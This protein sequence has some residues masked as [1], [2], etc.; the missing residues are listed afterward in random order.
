MLPQQ[1]EGAADNTPAAFGD[2]HAA[3]GLTAA[4]AG[5]GDHEPLFDQD[6]LAA[7]A[8]AVPGWAAVAAAAGSGELLDEDGSWLEAAADSAGGADGLLAAGGSG[9]FRAASGY[10]NFSLSRSGQ[11]AVSGLGVPLPRAGSNKWVR[12][13]L[14]TQE[15]ELFPGGEEPPGLFDYEAGLAQA[16]TQPEPAVQLQYMPEEFKPRSRREA[17]Y[18]IKWT[19]WVGQQERRAR[20]FNYEEKA[21]YYMCTQNKESHNHVVLEVLWASAATAGCL[22]GGGNRWDSLYPVWAR[23]EHRWYPT[24]RFAAYNKYVGENIGE[25]TVKPAPGADQEEDFDIMDDVFLMADDPGALGMDGPAAEAAAA[26]GEADPALTGP[27]GGLNLDSFLAG[28]L[29]GAAS[30]ELG[31]TYLEEVLAPEQDELLEDD[32]E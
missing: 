24:G 20:Q 25:L 21:R 6:D 11:L 23:A 19:N 27:A 32:L 9:S 5:S 13:G 16:E 8:A 17:E 2:G 7:A 31:S 1:L 12:P 10:P 26:A 3:G 28:V 29:P 18:L 30:S 22:W 14:Q 15:E 4:A